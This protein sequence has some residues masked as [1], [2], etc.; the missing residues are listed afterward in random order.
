VNDYPYRLTGG[1]TEHAAGLALHQEMDSLG[2]TAQTCTLASGGVNRCQEGT[3][4]AGAGLKVVM[5]I[6]PGKTRPNDWMM[7]IGHYDTVPQTIYGAYDNGAGTN[8]IRKLAHEFADIDTNRTLVFAFYN[9]EE[10]G[11]LASAQH[12]SQLQASGQQITSVFGFDMVGIAWPVA[13]E[14]VRNCLCIW[15]GPADGPTFDPLAAYVNFS[16]LGFPQANTKVRLSGVNSRNSDEQSFSARG[17]PTMR[18]A[19]MRTAG[20]YIAYHRYDDTIDTIISE[21]GGETYYEQG[22]ENTLKSVYYTALAVDNHLPVPSLTA[23][24]SGLTVS[25]DASSSTDEDG[26]LSGFSWD[27]GDGATGEGVTA[28]HTYAAPGSYTVT[29]TV[30]DNLHPQVTRTAI[31]TVTVG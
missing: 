31:T 3:V 4:G 29:L 5:G 16:F 12:A 14:T 24:L 6:K 8:F 25:M 11:L 22:I 15:R 7:F 1:P 19:G 23:D 10:E 2:Y 21:A 30:E 28:Q 17:Y 13:N 26:A 18:W 27:F 20:S 9:G